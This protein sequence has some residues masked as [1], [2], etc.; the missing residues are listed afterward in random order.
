SSGGYMFEIH[1]AIPTL[2]TAI[3]L[4]TIGALKAVGLLKSKYF[5]E[6]ND[7]P[8]DGQQQA[9]TP[10]TGHDLENPGVMTTIKISSL[11]EAIRMVTEGMA[12]LRQRGIEGNFEVEEIISPASEDITL[13]L[14]E[15]FPN[16]K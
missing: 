14:P 11:T 9:C 7:L 15:L 6:V 3:T 1:I 8:V 12:V 16:F 4:E 10:P 13:N 2:P 5:L